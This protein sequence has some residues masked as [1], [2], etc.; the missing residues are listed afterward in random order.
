MGKILTIFTGGT[1][2]SV[3]VYDPESKGYVIMQPSEARK[4]GCDSKKITS[5]LFDAYKKRFPQDKR[6]DDLE[7]MEL[8]EVLSENMK[9]DTWN[10]IIEALKNINFNKYEGIIITHGT[11]TLGYTANLISLLFANVN[12]PIVF[13]SSNYVPDDPKANGPHNLKGAID[14]IKNIGLPGVYATYRNNGE[15]KIIHGS[16][17]TQ[18]KQIYDD[19]DGI[20]NPNNSDSCPRLG[21]ALDNGGIIIEDKELYNSIIKRN[22]SGKNLADK[23]DNISANIIKINPYVGLDYRNY[24]FNNCDAILHTLYH[25]GTFCESFQDIADYYNSVHGL[26]ELRENKPVYF[27]PIYGD[28]NRDLYGSTDRFSKSKFLMNM[29][30]ECAYVK[31][32][33]AYS[34]SKYSGISKDDV[35]YGQISEEYIMPAKKLL[36][37]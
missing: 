8:M 11:D 30:E 32:L 31:L 24:N 27:G 33:I 9:V 34:L 36:K 25:A 23:I 1:I 21:V 22:H 29:S 18:C 3:R 15:T 20:Y 17:I 37:K 14:F 6:I 5:V 16:R 13:V 26:F 4:A 28:E 10:K 2:G 19:F 35:L 12:I 7:K